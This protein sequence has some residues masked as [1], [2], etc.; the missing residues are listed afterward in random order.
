M[1]I[2]KTRPRLLGAQAEA[3]AAEAQIDKEEGNKA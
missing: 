1:S 3:A 2:F